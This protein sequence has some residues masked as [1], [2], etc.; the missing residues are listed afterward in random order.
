MAMGNLNAERQALAQ[1]KKRARR[2]KR[3]ARGPLVELRADH[4]AAVRR[5]LVLLDGYLSTEKPDT[6]TAWD[7]GWM[8]YRELRQHAKAAIKL[9]PITSPDRGP[10]NG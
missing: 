6:L 3:P 8:T 1:I 2:L 9:L 4:V 7:G 5:V 10:G